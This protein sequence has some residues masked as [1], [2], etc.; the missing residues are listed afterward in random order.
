MPES[1]INYPIILV[2]II[3]ILILVIAYIYVKYVKKDVKLPDVIAPILDIKPE[4]VLETHPVEGSWLDIN[5]GESILDVVVEDHAVRLQ[6]VEKDGTVIKMEEDI[7]THSAEKITLKNGISLLYIKTTAILKYNFG[8]ISRTFRKYTELDA[9]S[10]QNVARAETQAAEDEAR[11]RTVTDTVRN[12][13][14]PMSRDEMLN[15]MG[16]K[17]FRNLPGGVE[18][19]YIVANV[20]TLSDKFSISHSD[21]KGGFTVP[22]MHV[23][24]AW[25]DNVIYARG[26]IDSKNITITYQGAAMTIQDGSQ[27]ILLARS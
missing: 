21:M 26:E 6:F 22:E 14:M 7:N 3:I 17:W 19:P 15:M 24:T 12:Y 18:I 10:D 27:L 9:V 4:I 5:D 11:E 1:T 8:D 20:D 16:G 25:D 13:P 23:V 2:V